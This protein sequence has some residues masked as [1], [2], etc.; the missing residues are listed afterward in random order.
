MNANP[1]GVDIALGVFGPGKFCGRFTRVRVRRDPQTGE[2]RV[3]GRRRVRRCY[4]P[5]LLQVRLE[6][7]YLGG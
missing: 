5:R 6:A 7:T 1:Y 4:T 2:R 3:V